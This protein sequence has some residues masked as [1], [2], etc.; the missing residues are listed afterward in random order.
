LLTSRIKNQRTASAKEL[1]SLKRQ[2]GLGSVELVLITMVLMVLMHV[3]L[4][5]AESLVHYHARVVEARNAAYKVELYL[6]GEPSIIDNAINTIDTEA[7]QPL[8][9]MLEQASPLLDYL[10][11]DTAVTG[12]SQYM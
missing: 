8:E 3:T 4:R 7:I 1:P 2:L 6:A 10:E 11:I 5:T 9:D 12:L